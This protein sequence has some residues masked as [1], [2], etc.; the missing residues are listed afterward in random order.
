M[1]TC[2]KDKPKRKRCHPKKKKCKVIKRLICISNCLSIKQPCDSK[3]QSYFRF[4]ASSCNF[5]SGTI[6]LKN[7]CRSC[8]M[9]MI[10]MFADN[11]QKTINVG[12]NSSS[13]VVVSDLI[14]IEIGCTGQT[15]TDCTGTLELELYYTLTY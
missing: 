4:L 10:L 11:S 5:P 3:P 9:L 15:E 6:T 1:S 14:S 13:T 8:S 2:H 7:S 12:P